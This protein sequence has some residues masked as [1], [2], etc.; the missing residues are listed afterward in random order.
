MRSFRIFLMAVLFSIQTQSQ[1][2]KY[3]IHTIAFYNFENLYDAVDDVFTND[4]EWTPN[5][6]QHWTTEKYHQKLNNLARVLFE[7]GTP[8]NSNAPTLIGGAEIENRD[9]LE[10]L[11]KEPKLQPLDLGIIH[12]D[13]PDKRGIDVALLYQKKYFRPTSYSNIPLIIYKKEIPK[14]EEETEV[15][16]E[17]IEVKR[18]DKNRV[19]TRDQLLVSGF[20]EDEEIHIIVNHWPSRSGGEKATSLFREAAGKLNRKI[21]DS[22]QQINPRAK[23][24]TMGDFNDGPLNK[25]IKVGL[26]AKGVK[27]E[28]AE[29]DVFNPFEELESKGFGTIAYRDSWNIFDQ[30]IMTASLVKSDFSTFNFWKAGIF[31]QPYLIQNS[32]QYKGYPLRNTLAEAGFS[33]HLPVYVYLIKEILR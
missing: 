18:E 27:A 19:F 1:S 13:S 22:L 6:A 32:G 11:I 21:I 15:L 33:D 5:G 25:S 12:F 9:V 3:K 24:L 4:D 29:F 7:I 23:I 8:E 10:D 14:K 31:N 30:I 28:A 16:D 17:E 26:G 2:K 20:L